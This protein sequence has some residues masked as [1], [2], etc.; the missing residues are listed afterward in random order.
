MTEYI[1]I[2]GV[3]AIVLLV[4]FK[5]YG[6]LVGVT[7]EG[8]NTEINTISTDI[9]AAGAEADPNAEP[10]RTGAGEDGED[11]APLLPQPPNNGG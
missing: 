5:S 7:V 2:A 3:I 4:V 6:R 10:T 9:E 8:G 1:I 11:D